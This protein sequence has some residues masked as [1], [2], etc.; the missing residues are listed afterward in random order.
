MRSAGGRY[1]SALR[2]YSCES[3]KQR[4]S[5]RCEKHTRGGTDRRDQI[6]IW[7]ARC[8]V[9]ND[10]EER[11]ACS[12]RRRWLGGPPGVRGQEGAAHNKSA[13]LVDG[14]LR[15]VAPLHDGRAEWAHK[16]EAHRVA[17]ELRHVARAC[18]RREGGH[19]GWLRCGDSSD[20]CLSSKWSETPASRLRLFCCHVDRVTTLPDLLPAARPCGTFAAH[21]FV[22]G[23][24]SPLTWA[25]RRAAR[26]CS[27][28]TAG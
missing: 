12:A 9:P 11:A 1:G 16:V 21:H 18:R 10:V 27:A 6:F 8:N 13:K 20:F 4:Q 3:A 7:R 26:S 24:R 23:T 17:Q 22:G 5:T 19:S 14:R 2:S 28:S 25:T 15:A